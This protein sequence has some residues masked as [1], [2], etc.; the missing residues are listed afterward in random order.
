MS[1]QEGQLLLQSAGDLVAR[2]V[3]ERGGFVRAYIEGHPR[4]GELLAR[5]ARRRGPARAEATRVLEAAPELCRRR[6]RVPLTPTQIEILRRVAEGDSNK[7]VA[8]R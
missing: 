8:P 4:R 3:R 7:A 5:A 2:F 1:Q 6:S